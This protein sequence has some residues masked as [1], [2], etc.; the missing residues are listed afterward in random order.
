MAPTPLTA[1]GRLSIQYSVD[2]HPH[3][4]HTFIEAF[5]LGSG[6]F[7]G[8]PVGADN[9]AE[10]ANVLGQGLYGCYYV[11]Q[12]VL[13]GSW[14]AEHR[15]SDGTFLPIF[16]GT[17]DLATQTKNAPGGLINPAMQMTTVHRTVTNKIVRHIL[18][19]MP[20]HEIVKYI[21]TGTIPIDAWETWALILNTNTA[22]VGRDGST[23]NTF[24][25]QAQDGNDKLRKEY[26]Q[27]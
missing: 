6:D 16:N 14:S 4:F 22:V 1:Y 27:I 5:D 2:G 9:V 24:V 13:V 17:V 12:T 21:S 18:F 23:L 19:G 25:S 11:N 26:G 8:N 7:L 15:Q 3:T 20:Q 10:L